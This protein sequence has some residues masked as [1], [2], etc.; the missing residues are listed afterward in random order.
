[1]SRYIKIVV[2]SAF[3]FR[4]AGVIF[5]AFHGVY[6]EDYIRAADPGLAIANVL[7]W[8]QVELGYALIGSTI[9]TLKSFV[10]GYNKAMGW[11]AA[12]EKRGLGG[13][14]NLGSYVRSGGRS[15]G[16]S[17]I[18]SGG[19]SK[20]RRQADDAV[21]L[22]P[23]QGQYNVGVS[24]GSFSGNKAVRRLSD[25]PSGDSEEPIIRRDVLVT[26]THE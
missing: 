24:H 4:L 9:P 11:E 8:Q 25:A 22:R 13:G 5:A 15:Q 1:M 14:Y 23:E 6:M 16:I 21:G 17:K 18:G 19:G 10:R 3:S 26:I 7:V 12:Y 2:V 20:I